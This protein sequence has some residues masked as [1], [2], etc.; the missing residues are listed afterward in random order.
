ML[1]TLSDEAI[2]ELRAICEKEIDHSFSTMEARITANNLFA[3]YDCLKDISQ[4]I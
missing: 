4:H 1:I 2:E 3:L